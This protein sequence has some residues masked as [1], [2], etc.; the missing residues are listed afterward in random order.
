[1]MIMI[2]L[3]M[4]GEMILRRLLNKTF[5]NWQR[6]C[7][8]TSLIIKTVPPAEIS[9]PV[10]IISI[11]INLLVEINRRRGRI[12]ILKTLAQKIVGHPSSP[13]SDHRYR[14]SGWW[15]ERRKDEG[16]CGWKTDVWMEVG[17]NQWMEKSMGGWMVGT[18]ITTADVNAG[19]SQ[20]Q[21]SSFRVG[22]HSI[23][24]KI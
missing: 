12:L 20:Q 18:A 11:N 24:C 14:I 5:L 3:M 10:L 9:G 7:W 15:M 16:V 6:R 22:I 13:L 19:R 1:M 8:T 23:I 21:A 2:T 17:A 4:L